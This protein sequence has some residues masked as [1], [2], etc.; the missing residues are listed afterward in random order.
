MAGRAPGPICISELGRG[1]VDAGTLSPGRSLPEVPLGAD[2]DRSG[3]QHEKPAGFFQPATE[4]TEAGMLT[5]DQVRQIHILE[6]FTERQGLEREVV[7]QEQESR[8]VTR[9]RR[10]AGVSLEEDHHIATRYL[11]RTKALFESAGT[12]V[13]AELNLIKEFPEHGQLR[14]WY[15]WKGRSYRFNMKGHH[16]EYNR[17][18]TETLSNAV[19]PGLP[20]D[21]ALSRILNITA[22]L[23][24]IIRR[25]PEVLSHGPDILPPALRKV[26]F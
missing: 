24:T 19:P 10:Q 26:A 14:G 8:H 16:P 4:A 5:P 23:E 22:R 18:V 12:H 25:H 2:P 20:P 9:T 3:R 21:A 1:W 17:W 7:Y 13:D 11:G 15:D 6:E